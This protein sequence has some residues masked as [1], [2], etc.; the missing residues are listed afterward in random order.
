MKM[1]ITGMILATDM[2]SHNV[3]IEDFKNKIANLSIEKDKNNSHLLIDTED[4]ENL[5]KNQQS[6]LELMLH[7]SDFSTYTRKFETLHD[8]TYLLFEEF[9]HQGDI[10]NDND[11]GFSFLCDRA[12]TN[13]A[14]SQPGFASFVVVPTWSIVTTIL[15]GVDE[16]LDRIKENLERWKTYEETEEDKKVYVR[17]NLDHKVNPCDVRV[18]SLLNQKDHSYFT[19]TKLQYSEV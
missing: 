12:T 11:K 9:F 16:A 8:W 17:E 14:K 10:E 4:T 1:R 13:V 3:H 2:A 18:I 6:M 5:F 7:S 15:P 19:D